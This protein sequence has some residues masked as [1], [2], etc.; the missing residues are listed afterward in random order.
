[1]KTPQEI[2]VVAHFL[3][4]SLL[5]G[6]TLD[7]LPSKPKFHVRTKNQDVHEVSIDELKAIFF[8]RDLSGSREYNERKGFLTEKDQGKKVLV[9]FFDGEVLF[10]YTL[11]YSAKGLGFFMIPGD[12]H[13]NNS[14][15]F[16]IHSAAKR[17]KIQV[18]PF[19]VSH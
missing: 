3:D 17:I 9:E 10:G 4:G 6:T 2:R 8:V 5:K 12:P 18:K 15:V 13:S 14:K 1:M 16:V 11:S 19:K 7:F